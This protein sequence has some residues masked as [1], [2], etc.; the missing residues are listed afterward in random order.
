MPWVQLTKLQNWCCVFCWRHHLNNHAVLFFAHDLGYYSTPILRCNVNSIIKYYLLLQ[1][2]S[3]VYIYSENNKDQRKFQKNIK[4]PWHQILFLQVLM[5]ESTV[6]FTSNY[7]FNSFDAFSNQLLVLISHKW[8]S[9]DVIICSIYCYLF[10]FGNYANYYRKLR[11]FI[12]MN[13]WNHIDNA[14]EIY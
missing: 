13:S 2:A 1:L 6:F 8:L 10:E 11:L 3:S 7:S 9:A 4:S 12:F 5:L 14:T